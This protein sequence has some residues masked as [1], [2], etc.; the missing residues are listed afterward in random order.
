MDAPASA[1]CGDAVPLALAAAWPASVPR[2][3]FTELPA[4][5]VA[6]PA[7]ST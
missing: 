3:E 7:L 4:G 5:F 2:D 1:L 6:A